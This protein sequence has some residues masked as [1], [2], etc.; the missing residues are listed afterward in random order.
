MEKGEIVT[1]NKILETLLEDDIHLVELGKFTN[2]K[3]LY[4][5]EWLLK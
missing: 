5:R 3:T 4:K 1:I 2:G